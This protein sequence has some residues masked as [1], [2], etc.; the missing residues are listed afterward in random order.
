MGRSMILPSNLPLQIG[1][2]WDHLHDYGCFAYCLATMAQVLKGSAQSQ[3]WVEEL[4]RHAI[5]MGDI[6]DNNIPIRSQDRAMW[7]DANKKP[8]PVWF[9]IYV[10]DP[11]GFLSLM[12]TDLSMPKA[13]VTDF[14]Y[15][16][17]DE[18]LHPENLIPCNFAVIS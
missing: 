17:P 10:K 3:T 1:A 13:R 9:R 12:L 16:A 6:L 5:N 7:E 14:Q 11:L 2:K 18:L 8:C 15:I 4:V